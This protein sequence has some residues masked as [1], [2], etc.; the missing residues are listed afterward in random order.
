MDKPTRK[1]FQAW[2]ETILPEI[3]NLTPNQQHR[4]Y[5]TL[6][7]IREL[8]KVQDA[9]DHLLPFIRYMWPGMIQNWHHVT[10]CNLLEEMETGSLLR[11]A[12]ATPPRYSKS[13]M[14]SVYFPAWVIGRNPT[15]YTKVIQAGNTHKLS[16]GFGRKCKGVIMSPQYMDL[17]PR[18]RISTDSKAAGKFTTTEGAEYYA[19]GVGGA[20]AGRGAM[21]LLLDDVFSEQDIL[22]GNA[23]DIFD[24]AEEWFYT[25]LERLQPGGRVCVLHTR[26]SKRDLIGRLEERMNKSKANEQYRIISIPA[27]NSDDQS[28]FP[29]FWK[30]EMLHQMRTTLMERSPHLWFAQYQQR[31]TSD[32]MAIIK[33]E[34]WN[35]W[36]KQDANGDYITPAMKYTLMV[37]DTAYTAKKRS[38]PT[39]CTVWGVFERETEED[40]RAENCLILLYSFQKKLELPDLKLET[41]RLVKEWEPDAVL[42]ENKSSGPWVLEE[43]RRC[44]ITAQG[45]MPKPSE[46]KMSRLNSVADIFAS[47]RVYY[48]PTQENEET[49]QQTADFPGGTGDDLV[50][51]VAYAL[52][53]FR[54][55][56]FVS[57]RFDYREPEK[58]PVMVNR[59]YY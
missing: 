11:A 1:Q 52:R 56:G 29:G 9:R 30:T 22:S 36:E 3:D 28:T 24:S 16:E 25:A 48:V 21:Y 39:A 53:R 59:N 31:P 20:L 15:D 38:N 43:F 54:Q 13:Q 14:L 58:E 42:V 8:D 45:V 10:I 57:S 35:K 17:F 40:K 33:R 4:L 55:G 49:V 41:Q 27:L 7:K 5:E 37:F 26:W 19:V 23:T 12:I 46:D 51:C 2:I 47:G 34:W 32:E 6:T 44:G 18:A 50:D